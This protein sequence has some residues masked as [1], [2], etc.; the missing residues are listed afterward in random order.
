MLVYIVIFVNNSLDNLTALFFYMTVYNFSLL[1]IFWTLKQFVS[2]NFKTLFAF[3]DLKLNYFFLTV[4]TISL[5]SIA[6]IPP[7]VGFFSK[8]LILLC[9]L[10]T[11]FFLFYIFFFA[12]LFFGLYFYLQN[13][14]FL[15]TT[16]SSN[17]AY[18]HEMVLR[19]PIAYVYH[20]FTLGFLL[21]FG[22]FCMD[23]ML[24]YFNWLFA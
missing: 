3:S 10:D 5:F 17:L 24:L 1:L 18:A 15:Y 16:G 11:N 20:S 12:L 4:V 14:R 2:F 22:M 13:I 9:L 19:M 6:G 23:D 8:L 7:F 21:I